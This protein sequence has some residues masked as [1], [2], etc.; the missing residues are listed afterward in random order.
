MTRLAIVTSAPTRDLHEY[1]HARLA[2]GE[3]V[4][5]DLGCGPSKAPGAFGVDVVGLAGVDLVHDLTRTP[6]PLPDSCADLVLLTHVLEHF[7]DPLAILAE[8][9][10]IA[11]PNGRVAIR[12]PHYSGVYAW[13]DPTHRR[14]FTFHSFSYFGENGYSYYTN[15]RFHVVSVRLKYFLE[16][17]FWPRPHRIWGRLVQRL[18][19]RHPTFSERFLAPWIG[20][21]DELQVTLD[22]VK[23]AT[24]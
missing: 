12:T 16:E 15:A 4:V 11:K 22:A 20:G 6:S 14:A 13:R 19:D 5:I 9:W 21:I 17:Q 18:L 7:D 1:I 2:A 10:R 8:A 23:P 3:P 24:A